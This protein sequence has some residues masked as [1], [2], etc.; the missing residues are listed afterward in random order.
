MDD[1]LKMFGFVYMWCDLKNNK[2]YIGSHAGLTKSI[3]YKSGNARMLNILKIRAATCRRV[4]LEYYYGTSREELYE[5]EEKWLKFYDVGNNSNFYN[6][7]S[8]AKGPYNLKSSK[9]G[10]KMSE[11][12]PGWINP[13]KGKTMK[14]ITGLDLPS[15]I[16]PKPFRLTIKEPNRDI[17]EMV[18]DTIE[19]C[20][21]NLKIS[22]GRILEMSACGEINISKIDKRTHHKFPLNT[23]ISHNYIDCDG[24]VMHYN[25]DAENRVRVEKILE[26]KKRQLAKQKLNNRGGNIGKPPKPFEVE[27]Y[28]PSGCSETL[29]CK[30]SKNFISLTKTNAVYLS[31][32]KARGYKIVESLSKNTKHSYPHGTVFI[33]RDYKDFE[34]KDTK[35]EKNIFTPFIL[36]AKSPIS[37]KDILCYSLK[38]AARKTNLNRSFFTKVKKDISVIRSNVKYTY[39]G[40]GM[41][42]LLKLYK[43]RNNVEI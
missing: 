27:I 8:F 35:S 23:L 14:E 9:R 13:N 24:K 11:M 37:N 2:Y 42:D 39:S 7:H 3:K 32:L 17:Y 36:N 21:S 5:M 40:I 30:N 34:S 41:E 12:K 10:R 6:C 28:Y 15:S 31:Q 26:R 16:P 33:L 19:E 18:Y 38:D 25:S 43:D 1:N 4:V 29:T 22:K 20:V